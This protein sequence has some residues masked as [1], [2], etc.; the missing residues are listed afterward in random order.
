M[1][2]M[3]YGFRYSVTAFARASYVHACADIPMCERARSRVCMW[4]EGNN[5]NNVTGMVMYLIMLTKCRYKRRYKAVTSRYIHR[6][7]LKIR[8]YSA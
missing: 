4:G 3:A 2:S 5:C 1:F 7:P 6:T 8:G